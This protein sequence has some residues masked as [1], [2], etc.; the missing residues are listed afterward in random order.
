M[1][2]ARRGG[3]LYTRLG[4]VFQVPAYSISH[5]ATFPAKNLVAFSEAAVEPRIFV[6]D[7]VNNSDKPLFVP[8]PRNLL[9]SPN[10][11]AWLSFVVRH[12]KTMNPLN[13]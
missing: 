2:R 1:G 10:L 13:R 5:V 11:A 6:Y 12:F 3:V 8:D 7:Y 4:P 9:A